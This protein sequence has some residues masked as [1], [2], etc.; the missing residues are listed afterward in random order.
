MDKLRE[1]RK[2][3][4]IAGS[5]TNQATS[6]PN[7]YAIGEVDYHYHGANRLGANSLLSCIFSGLFVA[8]GLE[9]LLDNLKP[10]ASAA[11]QPASIYEA[12][13][14]QQQERHD[15]LL[16]QSGDEN[17]YLIHQELGNMM[18][19]A[20]T[21]VRVNSQLEEGIGKLADLKQ[22]AWKCALSDT[23]NWSNQN[24]LFTKALQDMFPIAEAILKGALAR[25]ECRGAHYKPE[26]ELPGLTAED[27][28]E[29]RRQAEEWCDKFEANIEK[30]LKSSIATYDGDHVDINYEEVD[31][32]IEPPRPRLYGLVGAEEISIVWNERKAKK[33]A[34]AQ[35]A[36][37]TN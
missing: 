23:G 10:G 19:S 21:V 36:A 31:T 20:A 5:P 26:F 29:H 24:V 3:R 14:K 32:S 2:R 30:F 4:L 11:D 6:I 25:D 12:A 13:V 18:T 15:N 28:A 7:L 16:K 27:P 22:R 35:E 9:T 17:P 8:P 37:A 33:K 1:E 34:A